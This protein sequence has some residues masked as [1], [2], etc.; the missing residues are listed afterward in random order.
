MRINQSRAALDKRIKA[1]LFER[2]EAY[3]PEIHEHLGLPE[4]DYS[5]V[6]GR[7]ETLVKHGVLARRDVTARQLRK[8]RGAQSFYGRTYCRLAGTPAGK[9]APS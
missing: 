4:S 9:G 2:C 1:F 5:G 7:L 8:V 6:K 3:A